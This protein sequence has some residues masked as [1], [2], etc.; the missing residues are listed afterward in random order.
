M[1]QKLNPLGI[2]FFNITMPVVSAFGSSIYTTWFFVVFGVAVL[3]YFRLFKRAVK[4]TLFVTVF[5]VLYLYMMDIP[6]LRYFSSMFFISFMFVPIVIL[7]SILITEYHS[8]ELLSALEK[9]FLPKIFIVALTVT[10]RYVVIFKR[11]FLFI[12]ES[13]RIRGTPIS[14]R[15]PI[16]SFQNMITPQLFRCLVLSEE[17]TCA[18]LVKGISSKNK[19][20]SYFYKG[21]HAVDLI[22]VLVY[23]AGLTGV[24]LWMK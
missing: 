18:G 3:L 24:E 7:A 2:L 14:L 11:E 15:H 13:M 5:F 10:L 8:S 1:R 19:R 21:F 4:A 9:L 12:K 16:R 17:L 23:I 6:F 22:V 20:T